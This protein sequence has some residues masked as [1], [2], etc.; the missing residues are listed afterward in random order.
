MPI[1]YDDHSFHTEKERC[2]H[3]SD[4]IVFCFACISC[5]GT[6]FWAGI[7]DVTSRS[8]SVCCVLLFTEWYNQCAGRE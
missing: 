8:A 5:A 2:R 1:F 6:I 4:F 3:I 7:L